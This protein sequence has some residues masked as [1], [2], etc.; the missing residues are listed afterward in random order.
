MGISDR[1]QALVLRP[2]VQVFGSE[3][4]ARRRGQ[5]L[6]EEPVAATR[7]AE[8]FHCNRDACMPLPGAPMK[9]AAWWRKR[10]AEPD[11]LSA[12]CAPAEVVVLR[13]GEGHC[14]GKLVLDG[15]M[16]ARGGA[17]ELYRE[18]Q[19]W[20]VV[21]AQDLRGRRPWSASEGDDVASDG[22]G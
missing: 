4:W 1:G 6:L 21:W 16:L 12:L 11:E 18:P 17:A 19:G 20:R 13:T 8:T 3:L 10:P 2:K 5:A 9:V 7:L 22:G 14:P 15:P